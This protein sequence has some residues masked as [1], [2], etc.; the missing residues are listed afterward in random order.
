MSQF[1]L[2]KEL[3]SGGR[4]ALD[5]HTQIFNGPALFNLLPY[6]TILEHTVKTE[7]LKQSVLIPCPAHC[8]V[9]AI[10][11]LMAHHKN[12]RKLHLGIRYLVI[13]RE[14]GCNGRTSDSSIR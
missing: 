6:D 11:Q 4:L 13:S 7:I 1:I 9:H 3:P 14:F 5:I 10:I 8:L 12:S 2:T